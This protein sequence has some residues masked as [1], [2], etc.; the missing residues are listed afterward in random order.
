MLIK[1]IQRNG[2]AAKLIIDRCLLDLLGFERKVHMGM[3][4]N[5]LVISRALDPNAPSYTV[6]KSYRTASPSVVIPA[7][8]KK[9]FPAGSKVS[10]TT[11]GT[12]LFVKA[13]EE[14]LTC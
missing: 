2:T 13:Y 4:Q 9:V 7:D 1:T 6:T 11:D 3:S 14:D 8:V 5:T 12:S 10:I